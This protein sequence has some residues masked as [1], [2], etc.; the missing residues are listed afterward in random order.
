MWSGGSSGADSWYLST[1]GMYAP[2][3][4]VLE[5]G[6]RLRLQIGTGRYSYDSTQA[7][8]TG[9]D[10]VTFVGNVMEVEALVGYQL[11]IGP[12]VT[13]LFLGAAGARHDIAAAAPDDDVPGDPDNPLDGT[14]MGAAAVAEA[15]IDLTPQLWLSADADYRQAAATYQVGLAA[16]W[17]LLPWLSLGAEARMNGHEGYEDLRAGALARADTVWGE[18]SLKGGYDRVAKDEPS[19]YVEIGLLQRY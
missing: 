1:G 3:G 13:K 17:R 8:N 10:E 12:A 15:W 18:L 6:W 5:D 11:R 2:A 19:P 4:S 7:T 9:A 14:H 16:G